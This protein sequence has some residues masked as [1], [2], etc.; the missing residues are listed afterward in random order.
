MINAKQI[1]AQS[2]C[3]KRKVG[4][5][6]YRNNEVLSYGFNHGLDEKC[7]CSM[8]SKNPDVLHAEQM[9]LSHDID[10][11]GAILEV[12][13]APCL[14]CA[15]LIVGKGIKKVI[16]HDADKCGSGIKYLTNKG[17]IVCKN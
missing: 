12:T 15:K 9:A 2:T 4:C 7:S 13:Y 3:K 10:F 14:N 6:V 16:Y 17:V 5:V 8:S 11:G 1:A